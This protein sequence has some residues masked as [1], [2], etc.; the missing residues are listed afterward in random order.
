MTTAEQ[1]NPSVYEP[2][3][4]FICGSGGCNTTT[5]YQVR[6]DR[7]IAGNFLEEIGSWTTALQREQ[8]PPAGDAARAGRLRRRTVVG[9]RTRQATADAGQQPEERRM[10]AT[11]AQLRTHEHR[12]AAMIADPECVGE[13][14]LVGMGMA[15]CLDLGDPHWPAGEPMPIKPI[16]YAVYGRYRLGMDMLLPDRSAHGDSH[17]RKRILDVFFHDRRRYSATVDGDRSAGWSTTCGRP[18]LRRDGLC[19]RSASWDQK[20]RLTDPVTGQRR[21]VGACSQPKCLTCWPGIKPN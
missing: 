16:A 1:P 20:K 2:F 12:V 13:L 9:E 19:G 8:A 11:S 14:L 15:R 10:T 21:T 3:T 4:T 5:S 18:M 6:P 17:P 7:E